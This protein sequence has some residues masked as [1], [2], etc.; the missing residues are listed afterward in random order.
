MSRFAHVGRLRAAHA[1][2]ARARASANAWL[3]PP[4][5]EFARRLQREHATE[6]F[7]HDLV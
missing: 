1:A 3:T 6:D 5:G 2:P 7:V 4:A